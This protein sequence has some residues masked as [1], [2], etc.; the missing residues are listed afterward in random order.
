MT[1]GD[2]LKRPCI[3]RVYNWQNTLQP[4]NLFSIQ[5][6]TASMIIAL[7]VNFHRLFVLPLGLYLILI[8]DSIEEFLKVFIRESYNAGARWTETILNILLSVFG[9]GRARRYQHQH[10]QRQAWQLFQQ[11]LGS[12]T[13]TFN[14]VLE[15]EGYSVPSNG[16]NS[17]NKSIPIDSAES[18]RHPWWNKRRR[19]KPTPPPPPNLARGSVL[20][21][22]PSGYAATEAFQQ[23]GLLEDMRVGIEL[24]ITRAFRAFKGVVRLIF[25]I[26][27]DDQNSSGARTPRE[28]STS[29]WTASD[30]ILRAGYPLEEHVVTTDDGYVLHMQRVPKKSTTNVVFFQ[31]GVLDTSLG[32]VANGSTGS[33]AL[34]ASDEGFDVWLGNSRANPPRLHSDPARSSGGFFNKYFSYSVNELG[35][36]DIGA[37]ID[38][39]DKTKNTELGGEPY[40][41]QVVGHSLGGASLLVYA[42]VRCMKNTPHHI[43]RMILMSPAGFHSKIPRGLKPFQFVL[44]PLS[45]FLRVVTG[46][47]SV[48]L[49]LFGRL[50]RYMIFKLAHDLRSNPALQHLVKNFMRWATGGDRSEWDRALLLPHFSPSSMPALSSQCVEHF[51][52][53]AKDGRFALFDYN[54][55][56]GNM[57]VYGSGKAPSLSANY[58]LLDF[59]IDLTCGRRD[60]IISNVDVERHYTKMKSAGLRV[61]LHE[62]PY[63]HLDV[64]FAYKEDVRLY[65]LHKLLQGCQK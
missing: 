37:L 22:T 56:E 24:V 42:V 2:W 53:W 25:F 62:W 50:L 17:T 65:I 23:R 32:W 21:D 11:S 36:L 12:F 30:A 27:D 31:H 26:A 9:H 10:E 1:I 41:L 19:R 33:L 48:G 6:F 54:S 45:H 5:G 55:K 46:G 44:P 40:K 8:L 58:K 18:K 64:T 38:H 4:F 16:S 35:E 15:Q 7:V 34:A 13:G 61:T 47:R 59:P 39:I 63:G 20:F 52:Q 14:A 51:A 28:F 57:K 29:V 60:G 49:R 43:S 3:R